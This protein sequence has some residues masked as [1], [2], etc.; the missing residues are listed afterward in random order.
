M[1]VRVIIASDP[2]YDDARAIYNALYDRRPHAVVQ[3]TDL[4]DVMAVIAASTWPSEAAATAFPDS[5]Q[6]TMG[7]SSTSRP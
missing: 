5:A 2:D 7:W 4:A 1:R 3:R 6:W